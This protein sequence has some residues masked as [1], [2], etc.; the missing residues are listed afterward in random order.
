MEELTIKQRLLN[1]FRAAREC[2]GT[3]WRKELANSDPEWNS[4]EGAYIIN[5]VMGAASDSRRAGVDRIE[6]V[7]LALEKIILKYREEQPFE[8]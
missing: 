4:L 8:A 2:V 3:D 5:Q 7:V 6:K 1:R